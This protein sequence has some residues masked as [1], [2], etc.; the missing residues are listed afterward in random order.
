MASSRV[1][2]ASI[3]IDS[4]QQQQ[5]Q[6][7]SAMQMF[8]KYPTWLHQSSKFYLFQFWMPFQL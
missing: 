6:Q 3:F 8:A 1:Y 7:A 5:R 4:E 2:A